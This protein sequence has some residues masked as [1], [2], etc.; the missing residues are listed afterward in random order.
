MAK[1]EG[2]QYSLEWQ[3]YMFSKM[4]EGYTMKEAF[5]LACSYYPK[6]SNAVKFVGDKNLT[7]YDIF[8]NTPPSTPTIKG[9][10]NGKID[11]YY[12]YTIT[13]IDPDDDYIR[14]IIDWGDN[15]SYSTDLVKS[16][17]NITEGHIWRERGTYIIRVKAI[18]WR[19]EESNWATLEVSMPFKYI[20]QQVLPKW[21]HFLNVCGI[22]SLNLELIHFAQK[23]SHDKS[24][25]FSVDLKNV[26]LNIFYTFVYFKVEIYEFFVTKS[27]LYCNN[28]C[29]SMGCFLCL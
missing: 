13:T 12:P 8:P 22:F 7:V 16:G 5:D 6:I 27:T 1:S 11:T 17:E 26:F 3:D 15:T 25:Y 23:S 20:L 9:A 19:G 29:L 4:D 14:Y 21:C 10:T 24:I 18:D 28:S 2:W